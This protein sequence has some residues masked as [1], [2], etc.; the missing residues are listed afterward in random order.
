[1]VLAYTMPFWVLLLAWPLL[2]ERVRGRQWLAVLLAAGG[3]IFILEPWRL[4]SN[5]VSELL[6]L[7]A[8]LVWA[9]SAI[10]AKKLRSRVQVDLLSL[11]AWQML[12]G[13]VVVVA[14]A[15]L[16]PSRP[17]AV[18]PYFVGALVYNAVL[19]TA[20][21]WLLWLFVLDSLP[22]GVAGL[23]SLAVPAVGVL[24]AWIEL[25]ETPSATEFTGMLLIIAALA[26]LCAFALRARRR[27]ALARS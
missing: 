1:V 16:V 12:L 27:P 24:A 6:A 13:A 2:G 22:A 19:A 15:L 21:A 9:G 5:L 17:I 20:L 7:G 4:Q 18:T 23:S 26:M 3:L 14:V 8:G 25:G 11:T 10:L